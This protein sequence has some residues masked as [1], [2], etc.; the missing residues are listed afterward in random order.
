MDFSGY[1]DATEQAFAQEKEDMLYRV[2]G[3]GASWDDLMKLDAEAIEKANQL[4]FLKKTLKT[5]HLQILRTREEMMHMEL[6]NSPAA[7]TN[8]RSSFIQSS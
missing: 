2:D 7:S 1:F 3:I 4:R 6:K 5:S 8:S